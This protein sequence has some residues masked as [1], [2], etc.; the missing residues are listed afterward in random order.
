[1]ENNARS[2]VRRIQAEMSF[3]FIFLS[4]IWIEKTCVVFWVLDQLNVQTT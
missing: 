4:V 2:G 3:I 1:M